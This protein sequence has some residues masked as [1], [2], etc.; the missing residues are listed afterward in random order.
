MSTFYNERGKRM[1]DTAKKSRKSTPARTPEGREN[2]LINLAVDEAEKRLRNGSASSQLICLL[3][4]LATTKAKLELEKYRSDLRLSEA[5]IRQID[6][7]ESSGELYE[8]ALKAF[9]GY[10]GDPDDEEDWDEDD[11]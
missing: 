1:S 7:Q 6:S 11:Y 2:Q 5:K 3:L 4:N 8:K 10:S 9:K